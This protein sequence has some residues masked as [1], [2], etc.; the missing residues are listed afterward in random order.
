MISFA[1]GL[2]DPQLFPRR[3]LAQAF[4]DALLLPGC[5]ALQYGWPEGYTRLREVVAERLR[6]RGV[7]L[8]T[9]RVLITSGAQQAISIALRACVPPG[10]TVGIDAHSY[11]GAL[12]A[13][14]AHGSRSSS[15][16]LPA[17]A[18]YVMP[19]LSNPEGRTMS[20][21]D[22]ARL[23]AQARRSRAWLLEDD[24]YAETVFD[25]LPPA[26]LLAQAPERVFHIGTFSKALCPG[27]RIGWLVPPLSAFERCL[28]LKQ[29]S[30]LQ[31]NSL[32]QILIER[33]LTRGDF[34]AH[35]QRV[36]AR[37]RRRAWLLARA[38]RRELPQLRFQSPRGGFSIW[39]QSELPVDESALLD[40]ALQHGVSFDAGGAFCRDAEPSLCLR[41]SFSS[42]ADSEI[43]E[44]VRRLG[45]ALASC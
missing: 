36:R 38:L 32:T 9:A 33:Y 14:R 16:T 34:D 24:A 15:V 44:G 10:A 18:Y 40:S 19:A 35:L 8:D 26:P 1:G 37:Y 28:R 21:L 12:D 27:L 29:A 41:L 5:P 45:R 2:P 43:E 17:D 31:A 11:P 7:E 6:R 42:V 22:R 3:R 13:L 30:D 23:L 4:T 25:G 20:P 39:A